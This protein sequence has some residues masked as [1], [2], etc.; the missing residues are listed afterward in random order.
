MS[1]YTPAI[2]QGVTLLLGFAGQ[3]GSGKTYSALKVAQGIAGGRPFAVA[4]SES[5]RALHYADMFKFDH[6][7]IRPPFRPKAYLDKI[8]EAEAAGYPVIVVDNMSHEWIGEGGLHDWHDE[9]LN[10]QVERAR[11]YAEGKGWRFD[12]QKEEERLSTKAW[13]EPKVEHKKFVQRLTQL[14][15]HLVL[16]FRAEEKLEI[17]K[18]DVL[19]NSGRPTGKQKTEYRKL[20]SITGADGFVPITEKNLPYELTLSLLLKAD[21]P[22]VP[23]PIK[24]QEQHRPMFPLD[25]PITDE[26]GAAIARWASGGGAAPSHSNPAP[27]TAD[28]PA[29]D[30]GAV[31]AGFKVAAT[32]KELQTAGAAAQRLPEADKAPA[33]IAYREQLERIKSAT[34]PATADREPGS[35][36]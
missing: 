33:M 12:E 13:I 6:A 14:R 17:A 34:A 8:L 30:L 31:V 9:I 26:A 21:R 29:A 36:G 23:I 35:E 28:A 24:L 22:G 25:K 1:S 32:I 3:T 16:C 11:K 19:D 4:D 5:R 7:E 15:C 2:R 27:A 10:E 20:Q 18:V